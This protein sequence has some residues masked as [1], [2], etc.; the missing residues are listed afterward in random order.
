MLNRNLGSKFRVEI[1]A[2][3]T[4]GVF[5]PPTTLRN[6]LSLIQDYP[7]MVKQVNGGKGAPVRIDIEELSSLDARF[8]LQGRLRG[9][10]SVYNEAINKLE[11]MK[12]ADKEFKDWEKT[13][14]WDDEQQQQIDEYFTKL[15]K[16][17]SS[18]KHAISSM[19]KMKGP[20]QSHFDQ[21]FRNYGAGKENIPNRYMRELASLTH[22]VENI[23]FYW[24]PYTTASTHYIHWGSINCS[25]PGTEPVHV[26]YVASS[27][28]GFGNGGNILC[29]DIEP[30]F[31]SPEK[32]GG[33]PVS[34]LTGMTYVTPSKSTGFAY[35]AFCRLENATSVELVTGRNTCPPEM[36]L[37]YTGYLATN[38]KANSD[39]ICM[40]EQP[41]D[42]I[43]D[44]H[45]KKDGS[46]GMIVPLWVKCDEC[47][48]G[49]EKARYISCVVCSR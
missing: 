39:S 10:N 16:A 9:L 2:Y 28:R 17:F 15:R 35:C 4:T 14:L 40:A 18:M 3:A 47:D 45:A 1:S 13:K 31:E 23:P 48:E 24:L 42:K 34:R 37:E 12:V 30:E 8:A 36:K 44:L 19:D 11:D 46:A 22:H 25:P 27:P 7:S 20:N 49:E 43:I 33:S 21:A 6:V 41:D 38:I 5:S 29:L 32:Y 26:G